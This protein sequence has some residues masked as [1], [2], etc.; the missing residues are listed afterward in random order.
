ML[1]SSPLWRGAGGHNSYDEGFAALRAEQAVRDE[2]STVVDLSFDA[3]RHRPSS[4]VARSLNC[5]S[6][7]TLAI[8]SRKF[9]PESTT[10]R[11]TC[12]VHE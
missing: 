1:F 2:L 3:A 5:R 11:S 7:S 10:Y 4:S 6:K 9:S 12:R 8:N